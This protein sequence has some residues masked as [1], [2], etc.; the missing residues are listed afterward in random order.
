MRAFFSYCEQNW[1]DME[2]DGAKANRAL[3][4]FATANAKVNVDS[5]YGKRIKL[6]DNYLDGLRNKSVQLAQKRGPVPKLRLVSG[7]RG[8]VVV[9]GMLDD[10]PWQKCPVASIGRMWELQTGRQPIFGTSIK[11]AWIGNDLYLA[12]RCE[13]RPGTKPNIATTKTA[14]QAIWYGDAVEILL[15]TDSHSYYQIAVNPSGAMVDLDRGASRNNWFN[16]SS[17]AEVATLVADDHWTVEIRIPVTQDKNDPLHQVVGHKPTQS[18][19]WHINVCRQRIREDGS[20]YSAFS[21]TG[22]AGFHKPM[23]FAHFYAGRS[24]KFPA[25]PTATDYLVASR[26]A[27]ELLGGRKYD[28]SLAAFVALADGKVTDL[29]KSVALEQAIEAAHRLDDSKRV[30]QLIDQ[31]PIDAIAKTAKMKHLLHERKA[32]ELIA[33]FASEEIDGWPF[34]QQGAGYFARGRAY[35]ITRAGKAAEADLIRAR[36]W[37]SNKRTLQS[38]RLLL[39]NSR[40]RLLEDD[41]GALVAYREVLDP[42]RK[43]GGADEFAAVQG[44]ARILSKRDKFDEAIAAIDLAAIEDLKGYWRY[45]MLLTLGKTLKA[46][47]RNEEALAAY[48]KVLDDK[49]ASAGNRATAKNAIKELASPGEK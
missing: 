23:K 49:D 45:S 10:Q 9:D 19:P 28:E 29:Q 44:I 17:Q 5:V 4:L 1:R 15:D 36:T 42:P 22:T 26:A 6:I 31:I 8:E 39:G 21:P 38:I 20:E 24:H 33:A 41:D 13:E 47:G 7:S 48:H 35:A 12:I 40:E 37:T 2:K 32:P 34:W 27:T 30:T 16:W 14:D 3:E 25:D 18:L 46:A 11:T 43:L